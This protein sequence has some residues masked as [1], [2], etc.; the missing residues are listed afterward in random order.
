VFV[1]EF[2][3]RIVNIH[4]ALLPSFK[5]EHGIQDAFDY[6]VKTTGITVHFVDEEMDHGPIILQQAVPV[7]ETD[8]AETL[9]KRM[10]TV[11]HCLYPK[12]IKLFVEG[13][14]KVSGRKVRII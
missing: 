13:K 9:E 14:L 1:R 3:N 6:G 2:K 8:T 4:P 10:H 11:E 12:A 5:G 7:R